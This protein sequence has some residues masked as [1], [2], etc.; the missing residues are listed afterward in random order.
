MD[1]LRLVYEQT[2]RAIWMSHLD[3]MRTLRS[4]GASALSFFCA[5][6]FSAADL[7]LAFAFSSRTPLSGSS[8]M[9]GSASSASG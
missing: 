2:R 4:F 3:T 5:S 1:K 7:P 6:G 9:P 8:W